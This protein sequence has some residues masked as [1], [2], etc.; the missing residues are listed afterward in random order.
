[1]QR[2]EYFANCK[3]KL[4]KRPLRRPD[5]WSFCTY[6]KTL[7]S[8]FSA[9]REHIGSTLCLFSAPKMPPRCCLDAL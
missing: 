1:M 2:Y 8:I 5:Q 9:P 4:Q 7:A 3:K 6:S